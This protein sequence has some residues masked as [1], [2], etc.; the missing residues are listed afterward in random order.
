MAIMDFFKKKTSN[1]LD[2]LTGLNLANLKA[3]YLVDYDLKT[4]EVKAYN[5]YDWGEGD[6]SYEW[7]LVSSDDTIYLERESDDVDFWSISRKISFSSLGPGIKEHI[8]EHDDPPEQIVFDG[9]KYYLEEMSGG[10]FHKNGTGEGEPVIIW[11]YEDDSGKYF[12]GIEQWGEEDFEA[13]FGQA[14]EEYQ[15]TD[16][17]PRKKQN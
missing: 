14:V 12:L 9:K 10:H 3:G 17:L 13:S 16:I 2:P 11:N 1:E 6:I 8:M 4:W 5:T 7:Q 15:F